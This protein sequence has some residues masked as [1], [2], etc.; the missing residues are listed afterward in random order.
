MPFFGGGKEEENAKLHA[1]L[2]RIEA[3]SLQQLAAEG[4]TRVFGPGGQGAEGGAVKL[5]DG[6]GAFNPAEGLF[7][8]D[9]EALQA[10]YDVVAEGVQVLEHACLVRMVMGTDP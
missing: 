4:M 9:D 1:E 2:A 5:V 7:G 3:M 6:A 8:I 10:M